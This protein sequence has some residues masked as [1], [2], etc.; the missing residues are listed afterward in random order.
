ML[1]THHRLPR[2]QPKFVLSKTDRVIKCAIFT[3]GVIACLLATAW[4]L[5][6]RYDATQ[7]VVGATEHSMHLQEFLQDVSALKLYLEFGFLLEVATSLMARTEEFTDAE[8]AAEG[9]LVSTLQRKVRVHLTTMQQ[10]LKAFPEKGTKQFVDN[11][12]TQA[13]GGLAGEGMQQDIADA[14]QEFETNVADAKAVTLQ[15]SEKTL[16]ETA[17]MWDGAQE[18]LLAML[19]RVEQQAV[20]DQELQEVAVQTGGGSKRPGLGRYVTNFFNNLLIF[21]K[22]HAPRALLSGAV[23]LKLR[24]LRGLLVAKVEASKES[25]ERTLR[26]AEHQ[27]KEAVAHVSGLPPYHAGRFNHQLEAYLNDVLFRSHAFSLRR[28]STNP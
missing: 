8:R 20:Q 26:D 24:R 17:S 13:F 3:L 16:W 4:T 2:A 12:V 5:W 15:K 28:H 9:D 11:A 14:V 22:K 7:E 18:R 19:H 1:P 23:K 21:E 10:Q 25:S 6:T 27:V